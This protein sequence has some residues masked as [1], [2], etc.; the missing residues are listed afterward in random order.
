[1]K[2]DFLTKQL[3]GI[4]GSLLVTIVLVAGFATSTS[5]LQYPDA[6]VQATNIAAS[7]E[8]ITVTAT[9]LGGDHLA[10]GNQNCQTAVC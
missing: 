9:R 3:V 10:T 2:S 8:T 5:Q 4:L 1:M 7:A 6:P